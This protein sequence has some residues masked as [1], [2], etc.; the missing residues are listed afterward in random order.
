MAGQQAGYTAV[1]L[2]VN[3]IAERAVSRFADQHPGIWRGYS[4]VQRA[5]LREDYLMQ[6]RYL[7]ESLATGS[8]NIFIDY[9]DWARALFHAEGRPE[10][11]VH[12]TLEVLDEVL[13]EVLH[14]DFRGQS[15]AILRKG[16]EALKKRTPEIPSFII[17]ENPPGSIAQSYL[18]ALL[19]ADQE[20]ARSI[21]GEAME[22]GVTVREMYLGVMQPVLLETGRLWQLGKATIAQ[23]H[24]VTAS[25][26]AAI[27]VLHERIVSMRGRT[28]RKGKTLVAA[29]VGDELHDVGIRMVADF[30]AMDGWET[31]Y[32]GGN[33]PAQSLIR[34]VGEQKADLVAISAT[35]PFHISAV[36]Y[37]IRSLRADPETMKVKII[38]GGYPFNIVPDLWKQVGADAVAKNAEDA[39]R[40]GNRLTS[41]QKKKRI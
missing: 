13:Q 22:S 32:I 23:E 25:V 20:S 17:R 16:R 11:Y 12:S 4:P 40:A 10:D 8:A 33:I 19:A 21:I 9:V 31:Y 41:I 36:Q 15:A 34:A 27:T 24:Y 29:C 7:Q 5:R 2:D 28:K 38:V 18:D 30:F 26:Q 37:L 6:A 3:A 14:P 39:V 1:Q 35:M